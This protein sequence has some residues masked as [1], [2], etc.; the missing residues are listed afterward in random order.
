MNTPLPPVNSVSVGVGP[1]GRGRVAVVTRGAVVV[2][3]CDR[4]LL[5]L[6]EQEATP[7]SAMHITIA[8]RTR[9]RRAKR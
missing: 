9:T 8:A 1:G 7:G 6:L 2:L 4:A 3:D 5:W